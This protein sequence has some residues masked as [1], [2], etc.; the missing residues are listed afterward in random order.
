IYAQITWLEKNTDALE[1]VSGVPA[2]RFE[3]YQAFYKALFFEWDKKDV[4]GTAEEET[5]FEKMHAI[6]RAGFMNEYIFE[7]R[8]GLMFLPTDNF[9]HLESY[10][11]W[12]V[13]N[14]QYNVSDCKCYTLAYF[15]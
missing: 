10:H 8:G 3:G 4:P 15:R 9:L 14:H 13:V 2:F 6:D 12:L 5:Y 11:A 7:S 1:L